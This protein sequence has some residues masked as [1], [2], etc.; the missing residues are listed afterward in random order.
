M[1]CLCFCRTPSCLYSQSSLP[2]LLMYRTCRHT[3]I[4]LQHN[5]SLHHSQPQQQ[6][7]QFSKNNNRCQSPQL[8][9]SQPHHS[10]LQPNHPSLP[11]QNQHQLAVDSVCWIN[12]HIQL[13][14]C[15][16]I[17][18]FDLFQLKMFIQFFTDEVAPTLPEESNQNVSKASF[19]QFSHYQWSK[20]TI[21]H[22][23][24]CLFAIASNMDFQIIFMSFRYKNI[25]LFKN[26]QKQTVITHEFW[27]ILKQELK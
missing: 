2:L 17:L 21:I 14:F 3:T 5:H 10:P 15:K 7:H 12:S 8:N 1:K 22:S 26:V 11:Q 16:L 6:Q 4:Q 13:E 27:G 20:I 23:Y 19:S 24:M 25:F 9:P 18:R